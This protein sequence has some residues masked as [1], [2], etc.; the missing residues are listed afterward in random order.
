[1]DYPSKLSLKK[2]W[3]SMVNK[4]HAYKAT[5]RPSLMDLATRV[6][7]IDSGVVVADYPRDKVMHALQTDKLE[8]P[9]Y[10]SGADCCIFLWL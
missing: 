6:I 8:R 2:E 10:D 3:Q 5:H 9:K 1:M 7:V 4:D